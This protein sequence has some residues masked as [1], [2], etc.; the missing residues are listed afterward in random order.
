MGTRMCV[1][2]GRRDG[3]H[4]MVR[5]VVGVAGEVAVDL[6]G[7]AFGRGAHVH[8]SRACLERAASRGLARSLH[9]EVRCTPQGLRDSVAEAA[10][11]RVAGLL[12]S[13]AGAGR[14]VT[15]R[16]AL[17]AA[18]A[19]EE[20]SLLVVACDA[21]RVA[22]S[23]SVRRALERGRAVAWGSKAA[24]GELVQRREIAVL[25]VRSA[26][27]ANAIGAAC[28]IADNARSGSEVR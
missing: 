16:D 17:E 5:L 2:C 7:H 3:A 12:A 25:G 20:L 13:A 24:L 8:P 26:R 22:S 27:F 6:A 4:D 23:D 15:G 18:G 19:R 11:R 9:A 21:G 14:L 28:R 1:G 10:N